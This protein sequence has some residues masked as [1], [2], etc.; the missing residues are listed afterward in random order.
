MRTCVDKVTTKFIQNL[1]PNVG[2]KDIQIHYIA[3]TS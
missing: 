3:Y 1:C 2:A